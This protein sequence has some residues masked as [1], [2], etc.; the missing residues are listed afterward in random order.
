MNK[1][2]DNTIK[3]VFDIWVT[4]NNR[5]CIGQENIAIWTTE[6]VKSTGH[7]QMDYLKYDC[8]ILPLYTMTISE[9]KDNYDY[10][11]KKGSKSKGQIS[12]LINK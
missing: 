3:H 10:T 1:K 2:K 12:V 8:K 7:W 5:G 11:P 6:P 4:R 9:F